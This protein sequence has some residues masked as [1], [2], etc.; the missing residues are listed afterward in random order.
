[1]P[2]TLIPAGIEDV[3]GVNA[4]QMTVCAMPGRLRVKF[5]ADADVSVV[6]ADGRNIAAFHG[7]A[8]ENRVM[9]PPGIYIVT[10][11][12]LSIKHIVN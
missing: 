10:S 9:L 1:M 3:S 12:T 11:G 7:H 6:A 4:S 2:V 8:G 5:P